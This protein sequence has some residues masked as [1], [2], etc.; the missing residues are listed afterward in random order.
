MKRVLLVMVTLA[1]AC[2]VQADI[3]K[4]LSSS[5]N[6]KGEK[7]LK[8]A[9]QLYES[10]QYGQAIALYE[11]FREKN[12]QKKLTGET[13]YRMA[14]CYMELGTPAR[15]FPYIEEAF[16]RTPKD[17]DVQVLYAEYQ[18]ALGNPSG[19]IEV[20]R[21]IVQDHPEDYLSW[22]RLGELLAE[23][24]KLAEARNMW[25]T[26]SDLDPKRPEAWSRLS[27]SYLKVEKNKLQAYYYGRKLLDAAPPE[28]RPA[29]ETMLK[30]MAGDL[31]EDYENYY[32]IEDCMG[33]ARSAF[34]G[35]RFQDAYTIL[36]ECKDNPDLPG[37]YFLLMG[38]V[39][40]E[41]GKFRDAAF[42]YER[43]VALGLE[44]GDLCYRLGES[45]LKAGDRQRAVVAFKRALQYP[46]VRAKA[47]KMLEEISR[48]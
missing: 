31:I 43:C 36:R 13:L 20:Y 42:A 38:K 25:H 30:R 26:A 19:G 8:Q 39:C 45:Y 10:E 21:V 3:F 6:L 17:L 15:G 5:L 7:Y 16:S 40:D 48:K 14:I 41:I 44:N 32:R 9:D 29:I 22:I 2:Q 35:A 47:Q 33:R 34:K 12:K 18:I 46:D 1:L 11:K 24:G 23:D 27:E 28:D 37:E 4:K